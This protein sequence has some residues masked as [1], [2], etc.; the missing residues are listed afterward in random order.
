[1]ALILP[2][3]KFEAI[4]LKDVGGDTFLVEDDASH[5]ILGFRSNNFSPMV[6]IDLIMK[7]LE[8]Q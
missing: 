2:Q 8:S 6:L 3:T 5:Q 7:F 4:L 1:M